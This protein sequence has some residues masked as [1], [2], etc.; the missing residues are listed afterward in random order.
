SLACLRDGTTCIICV[1]NEKTKEVSCNPATGT[2]RVMG[3]KV[4]VN[5]STAAGTGTS[6]DT[7]TATATASA[8][9]TGTTTGT[10]TSTA[11]AT[12]PMGLVYDPT[13][14]SNGFT[15]GGT[16]CRTFAPAPRGNDQCPFRL[17]LSWKA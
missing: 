13:V 2:F 15:T 12:V 11:T 5:A 1:T 7:T 10:S 6:T 3:I 17:D 14:P 8:T 4:D 16:L 9:S